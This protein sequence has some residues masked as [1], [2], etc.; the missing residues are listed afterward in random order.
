M[1]RWWSQYTHKGVY[2]DTNRI[3]CNL[4]AQ[5][6]GWLDGSNYYKAANNHY[7]KFHS[8]LRPEG[9]SNTGT[10]IGTV[11]ANVANRA[12]RL[13]NKQNGITTSGGSG[14][15]ANSKSSKNET[16]LKNVHGNSYDL[17]RFSLNLPNQN[18]FSHTP[19]SITN[20]N[21]NA[22]TTSNELIFNDIFN[23]NNNNNSNNNNPT[24]TTCNSNATNPFNFNFSNAT[25][26]TQTISDL[27]S[28]TNCNIQTSTT[29]ASLDNSMQPSGGNLNNVNRVNN[30]TTATTN[31]T[32]SSL[33][34]TSLS[35]ITST[36]AKPIQDL[37]LISSANEENRDESNESSKSIKKVG[38]LLKT[39]NVKNDLLDRDF[40]CGRVT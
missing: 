15:H 36:L 30:V 40:V 4:C 10:I 25:N 34:N 35:S 18:V 16:K 19:T 33:F 8:E 32:G 3:K 13:K 9:I 22:R 20:C 5:H 37:E 29:A 2:K 1:T 6:N 7:N 12:K 27:L 26:L 17:S 31:G 28:K 11:S 38:I 23:N 21:S 24:D 39:L 14:N